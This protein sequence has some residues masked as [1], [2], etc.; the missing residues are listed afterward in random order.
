MFYRD[1]SEAGAVAGAGEAWQSAAFQ[2]RS[3]AEQSFPGVS[4]SYERI[5]RGV[6][7]DPELLAV[8]DALPVP[9]RQPNLLLAAVRYLVDPPTSAP[10][11]VE[12]PLASYPA[13]RELV[14]GRWDEVWAVM[15]AR[16]TQ[17]NEARRCATLLPALTAIPAPCPAAYGL[18][19]GGTPIALLEVGASAGLCL[20]PDRYAYRY[21]LDGAAG[22]VIGESALVLDCAA[23]GAVPIPERV[24]DV[25]WRAGLDL[26]PLDVND[27]EDV[28]WLRC[29]IWPEETHRFAVFDAAVA[30]ARAEAPRIVRGDLLTDL[31]RLAAEAPADATLVIYHSAVLAYLDEDGRARFRAELARIAAGR[32]TVWLSNEAGSVVVDHPD[33]AGRDCFVLA[34]DG[35]PLALTGGHG[36]W[37]GWLG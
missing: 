29:L 20:L 37:V 23:S 26:N 14:L 27:D 6:A 22:P 25:V 31:A 18:T 36:D 17:T 12:G 15:A 5:C 13:F 21:S 4:P 19:G 1:R 32:P 28:R 3:M 2:Y 7:G 35:V 30:I 10:P 9:K 11:P 24:P 16:R 8:L 34:R 33:A